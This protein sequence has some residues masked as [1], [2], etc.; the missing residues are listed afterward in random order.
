VT[1]TIHDSSS[2]IRPSAWWYLLPAVLAVGGTVAAVLMALSGVDRISD[3]D[4]QDGDE[5]I[6][7][8][9]RQLSVFAD[10][11]PLSSEGAAGPGACSLTPV[12]GGAEVLT[13]GSGF[14]LTLDEGSHHWVSIGIIPSDTPT[15]AYRLSCSGHRDDAVAVAATDKIKSGAFL[16]V[17]GIVTA[18]GGIV[19][20]L[21]A[22]IVVIVMRSRSKNRLR[23]EQALASGYHP[24]PY[25]YPPPP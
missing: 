18:V 10:V 4:R 24:P 20:A 3:V 22:L 19:S 14:E 12:N 17:A 7:V 8:G 1:H 2:R 25:G 13:Q 11:P 21:V 9:D 15:G 6:A 23:R 16:L 5:T